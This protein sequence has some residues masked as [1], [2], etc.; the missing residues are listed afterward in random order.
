MNVHLRPSTLHVLFLALFVCLAPAAAAEKMSLNSRAYEDPQNGYRLKTPKDWAAVPVPPSKGALGLLLYLEAKQPEQRRMFVFRLDVKKSRSDSSVR[1]DIGEILG[2]PHFG[3][4]GFEDRELVEEEQVELKKIEA[5]HRT[6]D[7]SSDAITVDTWTFRMDGYDICLVYTVAS[8]L[9]LKKRWMS[10]FAKSAKT[11]ELMEREE[12]TGGGSGDSYEDQLA[13]HETEASRTPGWRALPT[14]SKKFIIKTSSDASKF[15]KE[16][17]ERLEKSRQVFEE[18]F[19]PPEDFDHVS[20]VRLCGSEPEFHKYGGTGSG[21]AGYFNPA[22]T[23]LVL[24]D[25]QAVD[26]NMTYAVMTHEAF[27]Q[28][29]HFL[30]GQSEAHRWFDEGHGDYYGGIKFKGS[31]AKV[32]ARMPGGLDRLMGIKEMIRVGRGPKGYAPI[33]DHIN[34]THAQWQS[35]GPRNTS[36]YEQS[37]SIIYMLRQGAEGKVTRKV[38]KKEYADIVP[39]Y[40]K[41]LKAGFAEAYEELRGSAGDDVEL[42]SDRIDSER[43]EEIWKAAMEASWGQIDLDEFEQ[44][45][46]LYVRK[47]LKD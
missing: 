33:E 34:F 18:D 19:P 37:W 36:C 4:R 20:V 22:S 17:V 1:K 6:W 21:V 15:I 28:Y 24:Y 10:L 2:Y 41:T 45:W 14:P 44:N 32:T 46:K 27:H 38:W 25:A 12:L 47:Y 3:I 23:E 42:S 30:F 8:E 13:W 11:F 9:K 5:Q 39:S 43:K 26:R 7:V 35:Q 16:V 40:V 29:C 31:K